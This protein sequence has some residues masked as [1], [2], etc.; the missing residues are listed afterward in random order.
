MFNHTLAVHVIQSV[1]HWGKD[2][3]V[4]IK[5]PDEN[6]KSNLKNETK[7]TKKRKSRKHAEE[8]KALAKKLKQDNTTVIR[9]AR[10]RNELNELN[11]GNENIIVISLMILQYS[12]QSC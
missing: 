7:S 3:I 11:T 6:V 5:R 9:T 1:I 12:M 8:D 2:P 4:V 10:Q